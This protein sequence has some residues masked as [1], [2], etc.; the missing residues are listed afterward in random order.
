MRLKR[1]VKDYY[2]SLCN[3]VTDTLYCVILNTGHPA[4]FYNKATMEVYIIN[5]FQR[6]DVE[7]NIIKGETRIS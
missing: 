5:Y 6:K 3:A 1:Y 2:W 4:P 7:I